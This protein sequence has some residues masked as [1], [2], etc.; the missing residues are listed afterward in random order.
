MQPTAGTAS[1][2]PPAP[3]THTTLM[4][5]HLRVGWQRGR[6]YYN[7]AQTLCALP[8]PNNYQPPYSAVFF[9]VYKGANG[10][11]LDDT[12]V[13]TAFAWAFG[14]GVG[15][16]LLMIPTVLSFMRAKIEAKFNEDGTLK[17]VRPDCTM[18]ATILKPVQ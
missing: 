15:I 17:P 10:L 11:S 18:G 7:E 2:T 5:F 3:T 1:K 8:C 4:C 9:L 16:G 14:L 12:S 6:C 13:G